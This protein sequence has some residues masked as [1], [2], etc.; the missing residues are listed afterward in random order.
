M[1]YYIPVENYHNFQEKMRVLKKRA[2]KYSNVF[3]YTDN[4]IV[5]RVIDDIPVPF[6]DVDVEGYVG[7][8]GWEC[9]AKIEKV[10][11]H[12]N[13]VSLF[14]SDVVIPDSYNHCELVCEHC[15][16]NHIKRYGYIVHNKM[17]HELKLVGRGCMVEY[18][19]INSEIVALLA[20]IKRCVDSYGTSLPKE[21]YF[22][23]V[24]FVKV[25]AGLCRLNGGKYVHECSYRHK[26]TTLE[27]SNVVYR[28][29]HF[30]SHYHDYIDDL[31]D[32]V[33]SDIKT[34]EDEFNEIYRKCEDIAL[35]S[36]NEN[37][38]VIFRTGRLPRSFT[39]VVAEVVYTLYKDI[40]L[41]DETKV[42]EHH[43]FFGNVGDKFDVTVD[44]YERVTTIKTVINEYRTVHSYLYKFYVHDDNGSY[45]LTW[46]S[47]NVWSYDHK[48]G[49][50]YDETANMRIKGT[51][52]DHRV[53]DDD[54]ETL[55]TRCKVTI[56]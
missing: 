20:T 36:D 54:N 21:K 44:R 39:N 31:S 45:V 46:F 25:V 7:M 37:A 11:E 8:E 41:K 51:I 43:E 4:G 18:T 34:N 55:V 47:S 35:A 32:K 56:L 52:K 24:E 16:K 17:S 48:T 5:L 26:Y 42:K 30:K 9:V 53:Y 38:R 2:E 15:H 6:Y 3:N 29:I 33:K 14:S 10:A 19:G 49:N 13:V 40:D 50:H 28:T 27:T 22:N 23:T 1:K 12:E